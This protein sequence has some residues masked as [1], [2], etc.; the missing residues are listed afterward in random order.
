MISYV[1]CAE[2]RL[3]ARF[4]ITGSARRTVPARR[5]VVLWDPAKTEGGRCSV[6]DLRRQFGPPVTP[7]D[8][9]TGGVVLGYD[10]DVTSLPGPA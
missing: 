2:H 9:P 4:W 8:A 1:A 5:T 10:T 3:H 7:L 6:D